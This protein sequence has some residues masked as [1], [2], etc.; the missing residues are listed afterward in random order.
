MRIKTMAGIVL[1]AAIGYGCVGTKVHF[2]DAPLDKLDL[3]RGREVRSDTW[4]FHLFELIPIGVNDRQVHAY[5]LLKEKA[6]NDYLTN[7]QIQDAWHFVPLGVKYSTTMTA[8]AYPDKDAPAT[9]TT[10]NLTA[11]LNE[12]KTLHDKGELTDAEYEV[13]RKRALGI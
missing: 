1:F 11:R 4:G 7:I 3:S 9:A 6:G 13:A 5:E 12:L 8:T 10:Q 2:A